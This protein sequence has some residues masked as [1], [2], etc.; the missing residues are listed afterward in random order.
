TIRQRQRGFEAAMAERED[1]QG[2]VV[3]SN[4]VGTKAL[5]DGLL[6]GDYDVTAVFCWNDSVAV[7]M[8]ETL[9]GPDTPMPANFS[10]MGFDDLPIAGM[11]NPRLSTVRVDREAIGRGAIRL[12]AQRMDGEMAVQHLQIGL[13]LVAGETVFPA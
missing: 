8:V 3:C 11:A 4:E 6:A 7:S 2:V 12:L 10:I 13:S 9:L 1:G 5:L